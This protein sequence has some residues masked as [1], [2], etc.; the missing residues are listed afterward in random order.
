VKSKTKF[1]NNNGQIQI[2]LWSLTITVIL[3]GKHLLAAF[4][5]LLSTLVT[6]QGRHAITFWEQLE[7]T[8]FI[9]GCHWVTAPEQVKL[10]ED[11]VHRHCPQHVDTA[12]KVVHAT[13]EVVKGFGERAEKILATTTAN[14]LAAPSKESR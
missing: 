10:Y 2:R 1:R 4:V 12:E 14:P 3:P 7:I 5:L 11:L 8:S 6:P 9:A 13:V